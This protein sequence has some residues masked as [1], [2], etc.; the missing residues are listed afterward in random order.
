[1]N[2]EEIKRIEKGV[3]AAFDDYELFFLKEKIKKYESRE[4]E[5]ASAEIKEETGVAMRA[6]KG[7]RMVF[8]YT[9]DEGKEAIASLTSNTATILPFLEED[10]DRVFPEMTVPCQESEIYDSKGLSTDDREKVALL[11]DMERTILEHDARIKTTRNCELQE[12][13]IETVILNSRGVRA[14]AKKTLYTLMAMCVAKDADEASW[15][16]WSWAHSLRALDGASLGRTIAGRAVSLLSSKQINT[17]IYEGILTPGASCDLLDILASSFLAENLYKKKTRLAD[18]EGKRC[19]SPLVS[20]T[21]SGLTGMGT[22]PFDG[23]GTTSRVNPVVTEGILN[24]F[25]YD[26][27]YGRKF[28]KPS[29][30]NSVRSGLKDPPASAPRGFHIMKGKHDLNDRPLEGVI[31]AELMGTHTANPITGDFS[32]GATGYL[33]KNGSTTPF[34]G[35]ILSGNLF[36]LLTNVKGVGTDLTFYGAHGSPSL[37]VENLKISGI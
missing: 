29:T 14:E 24:G 19:F 33:K 31:I 36:E 22:F 5:I 2:H 23:E 8:S 15:F 12:T 27:Y 6:V 7:G 37:Y 3:K 1:M 18:K 4:K 17:G 26:T 16:D 20:I 9:F 21:D 11:M 28:G 35:V 10:R 25:L 13:E 34:T 32:L 30:G